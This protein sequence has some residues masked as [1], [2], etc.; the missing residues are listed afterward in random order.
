MTDNEKFYDLLDF[1]KGHGWKVEVSY[2]QIKYPKERR[3]CVEYFVISPMESIH[4]VLKYFFPIDER[5]YQSP[6][7]GKGLI[8]Y[9]GRLGWD[10]TNG[11]LSISSLHM[12]DKP[13]GFIS[14]GRNYRIAFNIEDESLDVKFLDK[15]ARVMKSID[16]MDPDPNIGKRSR[17]KRKIAKNKGVKSSEE[18]N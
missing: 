10:Q 2:K 4:F 16:Y 3:E 6:L 9:G 1:F 17:R 13:D 8:F 18:Q 11:C 12:T 15:S 7:V 5:L 14:E